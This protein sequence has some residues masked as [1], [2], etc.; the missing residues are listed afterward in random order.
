M[1]IFPIF[2]RTFSLILVFIVLASSCVNATV[3]VSVTLQGELS[4]TFLSYK[5]IERD[6]HLLLQSLP[7]LLDSCPPDEL[8]QL[9][10]WFL[11]TSLPLQILPFEAPVARYRH[12]VSG[13]LEVDQQLGLLSRHIVHLH[14]I[15][16][17]HELKEGFRKRKKE[18]AETFT[19]RRASIDPLVAGLRL[20]QILPA[21]RLWVTLKI[22]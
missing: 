12:G 4:A 7:H 1:S 10:R 2:G 14:H 13:G 3:T 21:Y 8:R 6:S 15:W 11:D 17:S 22:S 18:K 16:T 9:K 19:T 20:F 5:L